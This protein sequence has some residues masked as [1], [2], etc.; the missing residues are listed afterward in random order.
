MVKEGNTAIVFLVSVVV[1]QFESA[2][3]SKHTN[4]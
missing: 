1:K 4:L 2:C 3:G